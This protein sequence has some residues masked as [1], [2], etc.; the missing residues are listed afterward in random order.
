MLKSRSRL[1]G[2]VAVLAL[3]LWQRYCEPTELSPVLREEVR[4]DKR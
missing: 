3:A 1:R 4:E 2:V